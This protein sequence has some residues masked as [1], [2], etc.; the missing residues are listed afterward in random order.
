MRTHQRE[1]LS[2]DLVGFDIDLL[3][4]G[5][6]QLSSLDLL[7]STRLR[8]SC[9]SGVLDGVLVTGEGE[10]AVGQIRYAC[11]RRVALSVVG[12][13]RAR[14]EVQ[15]RR[16]CERSALDEADAI[17]GLRTGPIVP[18]ARGG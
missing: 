6:R 1:A 10:F 11:D 3:L 18:G 8:V 2:Q 16:H 15:C 5:F 7:R 14:G 9:V 12:S 4:I 17:L 13:G